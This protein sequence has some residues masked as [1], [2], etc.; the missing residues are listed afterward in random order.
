MHVLLVIDRLRFQDIRFLTNCLQQLLLK[1]LIW[2]CRLHLHGHLAVAVSLRRSLPLRSRRSLVEQV[3]DDGLLTRHRG[4]GRC[5][6]HQQGGGLSLFSR[7][8]SVML[9]E[10]HSKWPGVVDELA[11]DVECLGPQGRPFPH[12]EVDIGPQDKHPRESRSQRVGE[13]EHCQ[14]SLQLVLLVA[15]LVSKHLFHQADQVA[16]GD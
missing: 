7:V 16:S 4:G 8:V 13:Q 12:L 15:V 3:L 1:G 6:P 2:I 11:E 5:V 9:S 10:N 14:G